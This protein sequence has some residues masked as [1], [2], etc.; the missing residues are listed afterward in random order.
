MLE[1]Y[2]RNYSKLYFSF[3]S[4]LVFANNRAAGSRNKVQEFKF[5]TDLVN[6][7]LVT[8]PARYPIPFSSADY[9]SNY[10]FH[11]RVRNEN[12]LSLDVCMKERDLNDSKTLVLY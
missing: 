3:G 4:Y 8:V 5:F 11:N 2:C 7:C 12:F 6:R 10:E 1:N 9:W